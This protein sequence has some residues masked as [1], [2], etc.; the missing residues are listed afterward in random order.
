M[1][2]VAGKV[3][4]SNLAENHHATIAAFGSCRL[5]P[6]VDVPQNQQIDSRDAF[7]SDLA[8]STSFPLKDQL[9]CFVPLR[10]YMLPPVLFCDEVLELFKLRL[11]QQEV[12]GFSPNAHDLALSA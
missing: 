2:L 1:P 12:M 6:A 5:I 8:G 11:R 9:A 4:I 7:F 10:G 3:R